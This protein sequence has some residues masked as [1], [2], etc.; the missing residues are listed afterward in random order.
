MACMAT[1]SGTTIQL[2][3]ETTFGADPGSPA[4]ILLYHTKCGVV[5]KQ[6]KIQPKTITT[7]RV[8]TKPGRGNIDVSGGIGQELSAESSCFLLKHALSAPTTTGAGPYTHVFKPGALATSF[9][10]EKDFGSVISGTGR[11][12]KLNGCRIGSAAFN[13]P[14]EGYCT[15][16]YLVTGASQTL[17]TAT[18][19]ASPTDTG[20]NGFTIF[21]GAIEEGGSSIAVVTAAKFT[22][23][24]NLDGNVYV[25]GGAGKRKCLPEG[26]ADISGEITALFTSAS[27]LSKAVNNTASSLKITL[28]RGDGLG[29][30]GNESME[31]YLPDLVYDLN[32][33][34]VETPNG[35]MITLPF[36]AYRDGSDLGL[37]V[38]VKNALA[39]I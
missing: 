3:D 10:L 35:L 12:E 13:F 36:T 1:G 38:T 8:L 14:V 11:T 2:Y 33:V 4:G 19:D 6:N 20:H 25:I 37:H 16:D 28:S 34:P 9:L 32:S 7:Q 23:N 17:S 26:M 29:S 31:F 27:L 18:L 22:L 21:D 5:A 24:N 15:V 39:T 30:S